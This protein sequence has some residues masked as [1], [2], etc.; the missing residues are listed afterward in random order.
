MAYV[1]SD[2]WYRGSNSYRYNYQAWLQGYD[3]GNGSPATSFQA[4]QQPADTILSSLISIVVDDFAATTST[5]GTVAVGGTRTGNI[6]VSGDLDWFAVSLVSGLTYNFSLNAAPANGLADPYLVL[7]NSVGTLLDYNDDSTSDVTLNS[8][9]TY[10]ALSTGLYYLEAR[11]FSIE[12]GNYILAASVQGGASA[13]L[14]IAA[15]SAGK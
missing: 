6:E 1:N 9:L 13:S 3:S 15:T 12:T 10:T 14:S 2:S 5:T 4:V 7:R 8:L 11:A